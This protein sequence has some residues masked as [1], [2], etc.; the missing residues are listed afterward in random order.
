MTTTEERLAGAL[1]AA[2]R[3]IP[4]D[5]LRPLTVPERLP[6]RWAHHLA[7]VGA[8]A[9]VALAVSLALVLSHLGGVPPAAGRG[10]LGWVPAAPPAAPAAPPRYAAGIETGPQGARIVIRDTRTGRITATVPAPKLALAQPQLANLLPAHARESALGVAAGYNG[11]F[12]A[13]YG[14]TGDVAGPMWFRLEVF[15]VTASGQV[16]GLSPVKGGMPE[17][18]FAGPTV[19]AMAI[20][21]DGGRV[22]LAG[23]AGLGTRTPEI[24]V[25]ALR[26]GARQTWQGGLPPQRP[27]GLPHNL[28]AGLS[29][30]SVSWAPDGRSLVFLAGWCQG[31]YHEECPVPA[32]RAQVRALDLTA[33]GGPLT[34]GRVL[35]Q[36]SPGYPLIAQAVLT[37]GGASITA[38][39][40]DGNLL[41]PDGAPLPE[42]LRVV[43][44]PLAGGAPRLLYHGRFTGLELSL[45][46]DPS[47]SYWLLTGGSPA[48]W[49]H[50]GSLHPLPP[51][52]PASVTAA[53][54]IL[55]GAW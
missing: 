45:S 28:G 20:S 31:F 1:A 48:G 32:Q 2:A 36:Q 22:A 3:T 7:P 9:G 47:G 30:D 46:S 55:Q 21:P 41:A 38:A 19:T 39:V 43:Q 11:E 10:R 33:G 26:T 14:V 17:P 51:D 8:A 13:L 50:G 24:V 34:Q 25:I 16:T 15:H 53:R 54:H 12:A 23:Y 42:P 29:I 4:E 35:L 40:L 5:G 6:R 18:V 49:I 27:V 52:Q 37:P 44:I